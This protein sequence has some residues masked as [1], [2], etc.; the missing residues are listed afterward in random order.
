MENKSV[1]TGHT[2]LLYH[3]STMKLKEK[4]TEQAVH[5]QFDVTVIYPIDIVI[6]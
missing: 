4:M 2:L 1:Q 6:M 3:A 5:E